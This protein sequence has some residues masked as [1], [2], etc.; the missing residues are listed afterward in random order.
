ML[1]LP[2]GPPSACST[3]LQSRSCS[4]YDADCGGFSGGRG[5]GQQRG[6]I[7]PAGCRVRGAPR[8]VLP[9]KIPPPP[10]IPGRTALAEPMRPAPVC[11]FPHNL[12]DQPPGVDQIVDLAC[13]VQMGFGAISVQKDLNRLARTEKGS[14][15]MFDMNLCLWIKAGLDPRPRESS[16]ANPRKSKS[17]HAAFD[18]S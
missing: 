1:L 4:G 17:I 16:V 6:R 11:P 15:K 18:R 8:G 2:Y 3:C 14:Y 10:C 13:L 12:P 7:R 9:S 5:Q